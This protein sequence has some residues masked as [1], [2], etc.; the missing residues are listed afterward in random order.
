ML[1][2]SSK[3]RQTCVKGKLIKVLHCIGSFEKNE[4]EKLFP[5]RKSHVTFEQHCFKILIHF[6]AERGSAYFRNPFLTGKQSV[7]LLK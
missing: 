2:F 3:L 4:R 5:K 6:P 1:N 7:V